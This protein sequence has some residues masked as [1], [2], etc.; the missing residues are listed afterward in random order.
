MDISIRRLVSP[1]TTPT[2]DTEAARRWLVLSVASLVV[3]GLLALLLVVA[4]LPPF[5]GWVGDPAFFKRC[6]VVHVDLSLLVWFCSFIAG[7]S[8]L[9]PR[10]GPSS[11]RSR[12]GVWLAGAGVLLLLLSAG[13]PGAE[14]V[15]TN[16]VPV[17]DHWLFGLGL[18]V[19]GA[20]VLIAVTDARLLPPRTLLA[21]ASGPIALPPAAATALRSALLALLL[22]ALTFAASYATPLPGLS[23]SIAYELLHWGGG[24]VLQLATSL[25]MASAW[26]VLITRATGS[27]PIGP[28]AAAVCFAAITLPWLSAPVLALA[29]AQDA[30]ARRGFTELMRFGIFPGMLWLLLA[31]VRHLR[32]SRSDLSADPRLAGFAASAGLTLLGYALGAMIRGSSAIVP[33]HYHACIGAVTVAF[34][35][36]ALELAEPL[37]LKPPRGRLAEAVRR[38]QPLAFGVGQSVFAIGFALAG[39][40][41]AGRKTYGAEQHVRSAGEALGLSVMGAGGVI[42]V[43]AG[44]AFLSY[45]AAAWSAAFTTGGIDVRTSV[46]PRPSL[47]TRPR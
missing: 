14:P 44:V 11:R 20:G 27:S 41:G 30:E 32:R 2:N 3:A 34:M 29:G 8:F 26:I 13:A 43:I 25:A 10:R 39:A 16:Y 40:H 38:F 46:V 23:P 5:S 4:R 19:F 24:H 6:L 36:V 15:L 47:A 18:I 37:G 42:A 45:F 7:Q 21:V 17:V 33:A 9:L 31:C 22:S 1:S 12:A 28:R 35:T